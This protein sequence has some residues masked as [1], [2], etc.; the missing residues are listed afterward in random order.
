MGPK[1]HF[2]FSVVDFSQKD[3][4]DQSIIELYVSSKMTTLRLYLTTSQKQKDRDESAKHMIQC[5][6]LMNFLI[7]LYLSKWKRK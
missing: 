4:E 3:I 5:P 2:N 1:E 7:P 6:L